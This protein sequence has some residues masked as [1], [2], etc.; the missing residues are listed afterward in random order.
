MKAT[1]KYLI[2]LMSLLICTLIFYVVYFLYKDFFSNWR[3]VLFSFFLVVLIQLFIATMVKLSYK[4]LLK[5]SSLT[6]TIIALYIFSATI[7]YF[8]ILMIMLYLKHFV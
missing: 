5:K 8:A 2:A 3:L 6:F 4:K 1:G 7:F